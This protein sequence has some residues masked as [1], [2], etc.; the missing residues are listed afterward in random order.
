MIFIITIVVSWMGVGKCSIPDPKVKI[1]WPEE[2]RYHVEYKEIKAEPYFYWDDSYRPNEGAK[3]YG[4]VEAEGHG[5][6]APRP[7]EGELRIW[8]HKGPYI[9]RQFKV[10]VD[11]T[12]I[13]LIQPLLKQK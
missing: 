2:A 13:C 6:F 7:E 12:R 4:Y 11:E 3:A 1:E 10:T 8:F 5:W 9:C